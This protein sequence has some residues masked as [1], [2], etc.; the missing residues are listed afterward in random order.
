MG[1]MKQRKIFR[2]AVEFNLTEHCNLKCA[3][4]DHA[5]EALPAKFAD[6]DSFRA[7]LEAL[8]A[9]LHARELK[10]LGGEP[11]LHPRL[12]DFLRVA[13]AS[14]IADTITV[15]TNGVLL[16]RTDPSVLAMADRIRVSL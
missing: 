3:R 4:C 10:L 14:G 8:A 5:S 13:R 7:D 15:V 12:P 9:V 6:L 11:L 2:K 16:H 1:P